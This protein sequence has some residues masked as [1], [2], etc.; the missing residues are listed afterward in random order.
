MRA[1]THTA[2]PTRPAFAGLPSGGLELAAGYENG[3][4][5][6]WDLSQ[7]TVLRHAKPHDDPL[8][9][10]DLDSTGVL[11]VSA[12]ASDVMYGN[13]DII[14]DHLPRVFQL[15]PTPHALWSVFYLVPSLT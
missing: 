14:L 13:F 6:I 9:A 1:R 3:M 5:L 12:G 7:R 11:G 8:T 2:A 4:A 15:H 10:L